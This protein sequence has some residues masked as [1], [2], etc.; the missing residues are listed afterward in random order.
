MSSEEQSEAGQAP[1]ADRGERT[2]FARNQSEER[3]FDFEMDP[4]KEK[5][6][7]QCLQVNTGNRGHS[8][9]LREPFDACLHPFYVSPGQKERVFVSVIMRKWH[10]NRQSHD[11]RM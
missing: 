7:M 9:A 5:D 8:S 10:L 1:Q 4:S 6:K 11:C 3:Q 2:E